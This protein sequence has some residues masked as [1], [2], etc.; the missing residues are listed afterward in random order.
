[1]GK[2]AR[3]RAERR[4]A[5]E[6]ASPTLRLFHGTGAA[7]GPIV[8][9]RGMR[10]AERAGLLLCEDPEDARSHALAAAARFLTSG[11]DDRRAL[12]VEV[13]VPADRLRA[14]ETIDRHWWID[15]V[16]PGEIADLHYF[17]AEEL[18]DDEQVKELAG[19]FDTE[20]QDWRRAANGEMDA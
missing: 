15:E 17:A 2:G 12:L 1:M 9:A 19:V 7:T 14:E 20:N 18:Q 8:K 3:Q 11:H 13:E 16:R 6:E 4:E 5:A 10:P